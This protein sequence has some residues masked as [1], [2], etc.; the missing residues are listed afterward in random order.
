M[1][2]G[3]HVRGGPD[4][5]RAIVLD[6]L[7]DID[8]EN[9]LESPGHRHP[10]EGP[11]NDLATSRYLALAARLFEPASE[12]RVRLEADPSPR[13]IAAEGPSRRPEARADLQDVA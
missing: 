6:V 1:A 10:L 8:V 13:R 11:D 12:V 3:S 5:F 2:A 9:R 7:E 4:Q